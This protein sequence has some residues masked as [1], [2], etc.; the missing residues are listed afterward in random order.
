MRLRLGVLLPLA[1]L[2][3]STP[4]S[5]ADHLVL[6]DAPPE[7]SRDG[8][9]LELPAPTGDAPGPA[10]GDGPATCG[11]TA[12]DPRNC[13]ACGHDCLGGACLAGVCQAKTIVTSTAPLGLV[14]DATYVYWSTWHD[15]L[16]RAHL[17]GTNVE[18]M[19]TG[20]T[21]NI[22]SAL[23][24]DSEA[25]YWVSEGQLQR[26]AKAGC[27]GGPRLL[28]S[29]A[30]EIAVTAASVFWTAGGG[31]VHRASKVDGA[32]AGIVYFGSNASALAGDASVLYVADQ[33]SIHACPL[34]AGCPAGD[35]AVAMGQQV[36][37][38][39][40]VD[41][42]AAFWTRTNNGKRELVRLARNAPFTAPTVIG[43]DVIAA[44]LDAQNV[45]WC[46]AYGVVWS[47]PRTGCAGSP[48]RKVGAGIESA[49]ALAASGNAV[50]VAERFL[51]ANNEVTGSIVRLPR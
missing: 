39:L 22:F 20:T 50:Y 23:G 33:G 6:T 5:S 19:T 15:E 9:P 1:L 3:C 29:P 46:D 10:P 47:C 25:I 37:D 31:A 32:G 28:A 48:P 44:T 51:D 14:A 8:G 43:A 34:P 21:T 13:G 24:H 18:T 38:D 49:A 4:P 17:D 27:A 11:S 41:A 16:L 2:G 7:A 30:Y 42:D 35:V 36:V 26:C 40:M 12:V 45:T